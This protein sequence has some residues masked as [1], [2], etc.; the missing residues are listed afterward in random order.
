[1]FNLKMPVS[2]G[3]SLRQRLAVVGRTAGRLLRRFGRN[4]METE[5]EVSDDHHQNLGQRGTVQ[6]R[7]PCLLPQVPHGAP[8]HNIKVCVQGE[9]DS[10][11][12]LASGS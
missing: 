5:L 7:R 3:K 2:N 4:I 11:R 10:L 6:R 1:M 8:Y 9:R 12:Q